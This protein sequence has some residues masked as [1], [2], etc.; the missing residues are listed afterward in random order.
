MKNVSK[1]HAFGAPKAKKDKKSVLVLRFE[2]VLLATEAKQTRSKT[3]QNA[4]ETRATHKPIDTKNKITKQAKPVYSLK[5]SSSS[6]LENL[7]KQNVKTKATRK[8]IDNKSKL[9]KPMLMLVDST[10]SHQV[11]SSSSSETPS[12]RNT[13]N[14]KSRKFVQVNTP[15][16]SIPKSE[17]SSEERLRSP[18]SL[19]VVSMTP[20]QIAKKAWKISPKVTMSRGKDSARKEAKMK[21]KEGKII[22]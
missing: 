10:Q 18:K 22:F 16:N 4:V 19:E 12:P 3:K 21:L 7:Q 11:A 9:A 5:S 20:E 6:E 13:P 2:P 15:N 1:L 14:R 17:S 8:P